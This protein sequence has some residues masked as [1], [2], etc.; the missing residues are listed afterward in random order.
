MAQTVDA[1]GFSCPQPVLMATQ[2][3]KQVASNEVEVLVDN[4]ASREN[5]ARAAQ[6]QGWTVAVSEEAGSDHRI[7]L[8]KS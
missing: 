4:E 6:S 5:V 2:A 1:R 8:K 7:V 3:M